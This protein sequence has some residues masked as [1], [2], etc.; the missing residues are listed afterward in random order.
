LTLAV[1]KA[2]AAISGSSKNSNIIELRIKK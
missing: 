2:R 1:S